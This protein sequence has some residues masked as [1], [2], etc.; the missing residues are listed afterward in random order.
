MAVTDLAQDDLH[1]RPGQAPEK[2]EQGQQPHALQGTCR[3]IVRRR[4]HPDR[5]SSDRQNFANLAYGCRIGEIGDIRAQDAAGGGAALLI[6]VGRVEIEVADADVRR[7]L[8]ATTGDASQNF[9]PQETEGLHMLFHKSHVLRAAVFQIE[10]T[11]FLVRIH[12]AHFVHANL[13]SGMFFEG[14]Y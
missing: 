9:C 3:S 12:H 11:V 7:R 6:A 8:T 10:M 4:L 14:F 13:L 5:S 2:A 1:G